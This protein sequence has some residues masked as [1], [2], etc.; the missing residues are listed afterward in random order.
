MH[1]SQTTRHSQL[2]RLGV[3]VDDIP[4]CVTTGFHVYVCGGLTQCVR[5]EYVH[6]TPLT[7]CPCGQCVSAWL[8]CVSQ[9]LGQLS[10][11][12]WEN[13]SLQFFFLILVLF[14]YF[15]FSSLSCVFFLFCPFLLFFLIFILFLCFWLLLIFVVNILFLTSPIFFSS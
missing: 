3:Y 14:S 12:W 2:A 8:W 4:L 6:T 7:A 15:S 13:K 1:S 5:N 11:V 9:P 10:Y